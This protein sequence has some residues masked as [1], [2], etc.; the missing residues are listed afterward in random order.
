MRL[1]GHLK[2]EADARKF[3][4]YLTSAHIPGQVEGEPDGTWAVWV[5]NEDQIS[6]GHA[7]LEAYLKNPN[8]ARYAGAEKKAAAL[9]QK[10]RADN[11]AAAKRMMT[12]DALQPRAARAP[13]TLIFLAISVATT[14]VARTEEYRYWIY[15][16]WP[17]IMH[18]QVWRLIAPIFLHFGV[19]HILFDMWMLYDLGGFLERH[20]GTGRLLL[21]TIIMGVGSNCCQYFMQG[22]FFGGF[23]GVL[24]GYFGY[25]WIRSRVD[26]HSGMMVSGQWV[27][28]MLAWFILCWLHLLGD[29]ANWTHTGGL[30]IGM[31]WGALPRLGLDRRR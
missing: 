8:D 11:L 28:M 15:F 5:H 19:M 23:S 9:E 25:M 31:A 1:I 2:S 14:F 16:S 26:P 10:R 17:E 13:L 6:Q 7:A 4:A 18:G 22:P 27:S 3:G 21:M 12:R 30:L 20:E 24:Y 29:I